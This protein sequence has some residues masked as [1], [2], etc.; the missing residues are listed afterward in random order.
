[1]N[2]SG[3][4][5]CQDQAQPMPQSA[6]P[7]RHGNGNEERDIDGGK[8]A[9]QRVDNAGP[10]GGLSGADGEPAVKPWPAPT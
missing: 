1:M 9:E 4:A 5:A 10:P 8:D 7:P 3:W 6:R 2:P